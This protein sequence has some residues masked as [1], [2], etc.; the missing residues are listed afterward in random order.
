MIVDK[1]GGVDWYFN[2]LL[3][4][5]DFDQE[6]LPLSWSNEFFYICIESVGLGDELEVG[7]NILTSC[8][9]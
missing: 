7:T 2:G 3:G 1:A 6:W 9:F 4:L 5:T 8:G